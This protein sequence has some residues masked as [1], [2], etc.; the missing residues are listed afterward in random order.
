[1]AI[2][3]GRIKNELE[4]A[5]YTNVNREERELDPGE[6][7]APTEKTYKALEF[8]HRPD[9][10][11]N[12]SGKIP[13]PLFTLTLRYVDRAKATELQKSART[14]Q[15]LVF[16]PKSKQAVYVATPMEPDQAD[17]LS[18]EAIDYQIGGWGQGEVLDALGQ[19]R[20]CDLDAKLDLLEAMPGLGSFIFAFT[21]D[22][23]NY[24]GQGGE[25]KS[26]T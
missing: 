20:A 16:E 5:V 13:E 15:K 14:K 23:K 19:P 3:I 10:A 2:R 25:K 12:G 21:R 24:Q 18:R 17:K 1:V 26:T 22:P 8:T 4:V 9:L 7:G 11:T 6:V